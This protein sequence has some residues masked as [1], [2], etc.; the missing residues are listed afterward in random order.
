MCVLTHTRLCIGLFRKVDL[1][2]ADAPAADRL[3]Y[4]VVAFGISSPPVD[5]RT[6]VFASQTTK[7]THRVALAECDSDAVPLVGATPVEDRPEVEIVV[8][9]VRYTE[10][11]DR[12]GDDA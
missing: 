11:R 3:G 9:R 8:P 4:A 7:A 2:R 10:G 6:G 5:C 1:L 12:R